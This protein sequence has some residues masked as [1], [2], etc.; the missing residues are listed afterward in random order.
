MA[1]FGRFF[2][3]TK[4]ESLIGEVVAYL[5]ANPENEIVSISHSSDSNNIKRFTAIVFLRSYE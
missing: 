1:L 2:E 3:S 5:E 4:A